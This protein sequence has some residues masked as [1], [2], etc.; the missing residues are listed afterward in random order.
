MQQ[1]NEQIKAELRHLSEPALCKFNQKLLP[2]TEH[3]LGVR[4][5][6]LREMAK[7]LA[8]GDWKTY[9]SEASDDSFE[10][11]ML[12]GL[13][14]GYVKAEPEEILSALSAF[15]PKIDNWSVC[16][17]TAA[18]I[19][20]AKKY[21]E[22]FLSFLLPRLT[23]T[24]FSC[25]FALVM[26]LDH[27]I[28]ETYIDTVLSCADFRPDGYYAQMALAW[29]ISVCY[30]KFPGKTKTFLQNCS[31]DDTTFNKSIQKI[32]ESYR[33]SDEAKKQLAAMKR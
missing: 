1:I 18:G 14:I 21:P 31:L 19:K 27:F 17:S 25:R 15:I 9:L 24:E 26:L 28:N 20:Y 16:D 11:I 5:P 10:E 2:D 32:R 7:N 4:I 30:I 29:L 3:V 23:G 8:G 12:Q 33:V 13:T 6:A 22:Q